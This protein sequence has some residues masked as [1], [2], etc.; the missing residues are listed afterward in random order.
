MQIILVLI[1]RNTLK[2]FINIQIKKYAKQSKNHKDV[3]EENK[4]WYMK[5]DT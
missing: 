3:V 5:W 4:H 2:N 1:T